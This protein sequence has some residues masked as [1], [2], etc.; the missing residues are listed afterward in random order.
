MANLDFWRSDR[1]VPR[2]LLEE[3]WSAWDD[4]DRANTP[5]RF[6]NQQ[7]LSPACDIAETENSFVLTFDAPGLK[8]EDINIEVTGRQL[9]IS[10]ERKCEEELQQGNSHRVERSFGKFQ[11]VFDLPAGTNTEAVEASYENGVLK[12]AVPKAEAVKT[13]KVAIGEGAKTF[14]KE[15]TSKSETQTLHA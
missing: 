7:K 14:F 5:A 12:V 13:R 1:T 6:Q 9:S 8:R 4:F 3:M 15:P 10:G 11:R 2:S